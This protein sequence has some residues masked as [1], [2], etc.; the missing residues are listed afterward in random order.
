MLNGMD[1]N[2]IINTPHYIMTPMRSEEMPQLLALCSKEG[3]TYPYIHTNPKTQHLPL[4]QRVADYA[5]LGDECAMGNEGR[6][7]IQSIYRH[8]DGKFVG[9]AILY[10][11]SPE[12]TLFSNVNPG[13][14]WEIGAFV[15]IDHWK[16]NIANETLYHIIKYGAE[17]WGLQ[18]IHASMEPSRKGSLSISENFG[19]EF[20]ELI[21]P[22]SSRVPYNDDEG[23]PASRMIYRTPDDWDFN[24]SITL[25]PETLKLII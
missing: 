24:T 12:S 7:L 1:Y 21:Q 10:E 13:K 11:V 17:N 16:E 5:A 2:V 23:K 19:L 14:A 25:K 18:Q 9:A 15:D 3:F 6:S 22:G 4:E 8:S 20:V